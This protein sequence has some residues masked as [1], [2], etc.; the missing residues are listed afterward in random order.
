M[1]LI[2]PCIVALLL[3]VTTAAS[4]QADREAM[5]AQQRRNR[6]D[7]YRSMQNIVR[8]MQRLDVK[9]VE[10]VF[11][12]KV[13]GK[14]LAI[15]LP[16]PES[17]KKRTGQF[18]LELDGFSGPTYIQLSNVSQFQA[19]QMQPPGAAQQPQQNTRTFSLLSYDMPN[20]DTLTTTSVQSYPS[21]FHVERNTQLNDGHWMV[22][23]M[24]QRSPDMPDGGTVQLWVNQYGGGAT[25][26][27]N[28][29]IQAADFTTLVRE[30]PNEVEQYIRPLLRQLGQEQMFAPDARIAWQVLSDYW[31]ADQ[32]ILR[33]VQTVLPD[34][35]HA[36]FRQREK[37]L[38]QLLKLDR[39]G[40]AV[41]RHLDR[42]GF[43][44]EKNLMIDRALAPYAQ[45]PEREMQRMASDKPFLLDCLYS[46]DEP[47]RTAAIQQLGKLTGRDDLRY[48]PKG[49]AADRFAAARL[50]REKIMGRPA[51]RP[52]V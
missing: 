15:N 10:D 27:V 41:L 50:L 48:D 44:A 21:Y 19:R 43:S 52:G 38:D 37:A 31:P 8:N 25:Q 29:N 1:R 28:L 33:Q 17:T 14:S 45:L 40:A 16:L 7:Q 42:S 24:E 49:T 47:I 2:R 20:P 39:Q 9:R 12:I 6:Q 22:R 36:D 35:D 11:Q 4:A 3:L 13:E 51:T 32:E 18:R 46:D 23:I 34:L 26:P 5:L 30:N